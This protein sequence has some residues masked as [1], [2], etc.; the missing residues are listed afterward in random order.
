MAQKCT[1]EF[2]NTKIPNTFFFSEYY[3]V[4]LLQIT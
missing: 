4:D 2:N 1:P 3:R